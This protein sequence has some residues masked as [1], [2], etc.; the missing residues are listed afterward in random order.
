MIL[1]Y[2]F[3]APTD[4]I[5]SSNWTKS[6][7]LISIKGKN[8]SLFISKTQLSVC[9]FVCLCVCPTVTSLS[10][11]PWALY[12]WIFISTKKQNKV[13][14][15]KG[16]LLDTLDVMNMKCRIRIVYGYRND[17]YTGCGYGYVIISDYSLV[18]K[19]FS[20]GY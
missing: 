18:S 15:F 13:N 7:P 3:S 17:Y 9:L 1:F 2:H 16:S 19:N 5:K 8:R 10:Y 14:T 4:K 20:Y 12:G 6:W 11:K